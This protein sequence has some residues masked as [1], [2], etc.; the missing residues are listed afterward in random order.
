M[1]TVNDLLS[2]VAVSIKTSAT[3]PTSK[4]LFIKIDLSD[5]VTKYINQKTLD[6]NDYG[7]HWNR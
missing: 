7:L 5:T 2:P 6:Y 1:D 4:Q 3:L